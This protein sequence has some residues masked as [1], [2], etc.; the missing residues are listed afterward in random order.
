MNTTVE[1][2]SKI[3]TSCGFCCDGTLFNYAQ[4]NDVKDLESIKKLGL[5]KINKEG[6][7]FF[8]LPCCHFDQKCTVY[9]QSKPEICSKFFC[10][11]IKKIKKGNY[12]SLI[13]I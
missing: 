4:V 5:T 9:D 10:E 12:L 6:R 2:I 7:S 8:K 11:P 13:H 3:C 1:K